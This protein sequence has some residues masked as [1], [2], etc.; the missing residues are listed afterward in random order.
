MCVRAG[1]WLRERERKKSSFSYSFQFFRIQ[2]KDD[3]VSTAEPVGALRSAGPHPFPSAVG[4]VAARK[5]PQSTVLWDCAVYQTLRGKINTL[6]V[7]SK[8]F[9]T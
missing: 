7:L 8:C 1:G 3:S 6:N 2:V 9:H 4:E 5:T